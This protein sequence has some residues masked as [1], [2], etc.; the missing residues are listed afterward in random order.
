MWESQIL[1]QK[2]SRT[3]GIC[4][5]ETRNCLC[6]KSVCGVSGRMEGEKREGG[7]RRGWKSEKDGREEEER[8][9][10]VKDEDGLE[11]VWDS[12]E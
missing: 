6:W 1:L 12:K 10:E 7:G 8:V 11:I 9:R 4:E 2:G 3:A 5:L